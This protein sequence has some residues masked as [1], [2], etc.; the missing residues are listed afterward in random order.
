MCKKMLFLLFKK[1]HDNAMH[2]IWEIWLQLCHDY[3]IETAIIDFFKLRKSF[4]YYSLGLF[5][6]SCFGQK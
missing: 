2:N 6:D 5:L 3:K 1:V 4:Y